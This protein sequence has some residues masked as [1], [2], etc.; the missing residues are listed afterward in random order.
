MAKVVGSLKH[1]SAPLLTK[2]G[3]KSEARPIDPQDTK[4]EVTVD[5]K[6]EEKSVLEAVRKY[7][8]ALAAKKAAEEEAGVYAEVLRA[9]VGDVRTENAAQGD[10]QKTYRV[11]GDQYT[12]GK[13]K[14]QAQTD[15]TGADKFT[16]RKGVDLDAVRKRVGA[17]SFDT[18]A[19]QEETIT[20]NE[21]ILKNRAERKELSKLLLEKF[22]VEGIK[23]YFVR[24]AVWVTKDGMDKTQHTLAPEVKAILAECFQQAADSVKDVSQEI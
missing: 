12:E 7:C 24:E 2:S 21:A 17:A 10:Y 1:A 14:M 15:V 11:V 3:A 16:R 9:F 18:V 20:F 22:G 4:V 19:E 8:Q 5:G 6:P 13:V 23:K